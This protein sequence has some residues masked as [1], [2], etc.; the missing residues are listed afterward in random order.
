[1]ARRSPTLEAMSK[2]DRSALEKRL[3]DRQS[4]KCFICDDAIDLLLQEGQL[5]VDHI[6]PLNA[7]GPDEEN[8]FAIVHLSCNRI[9]GA[10]DLRVARRMAEFERLQETARKNGQRGANLGHLLNRYGGA[11]ARLRLKHTGDHIE[12]SL[13]EVGDTRILTAPLLKDPLSEMEFF[14]AELPLEYLHH[15]DRINPRSIGSSIRAL[16]EEFMKKRPQLHIA[17][18]WWSPDAEGSGPVKVFDG[19]HK[20]A[21][22]I[23]LGV[24]QLPVRIFLEP[25]TNVLL[26][27]NT[28]AGG[29]LRQVAFDT[30]VMRHLG[31]TLYVER[32]RQFQNMK[33][34]KEDDYSFSE[35]DLV[36]F[37]RGEHRDML[38]YIID[39]T[40]DA[41]THNKENRLMEFVEWAGKS[42][43][44]PLAYSTIERTFFREFVYKKALESAIEE[45]VGQGDNPR[46]LEQDQIVRLMNLFADIFFVGQWDPEVGGRRLENRLQKGNVIPENHLRGWR[47]A[48]EEILANVMRWVRLV[49]ENYYAWTGKP[50]QKEKLLH[51]GSP[52][53][54]WRRIDLFL[55]NLA[56]LPC[57]VD[58]N[59]SN[60]VFGAKQNL[61][62]WARVFETGIT[63][64]G[65]RVLAQ[66]LELSRMIQENLPIGEN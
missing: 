16:I 7:N 45:G 61:D 53:E 33:G 24:K 19:Q 50:V 39:A 5:E 55:R 65:V 28:N 12:Y 8:N 63:P 4:G 17:L 44:R 1:M 59:L 47:I 57:W 11:R 18:A 23:L 27:T 6:V 51:R 30:A 38:R 15:D 9:K 49:I 64:T 56:E 22:Q 35:K 20:A 26:Q 46:M 37:F 41:I 2:E 13:A 40:R 3:C 60:T 52:E 31:S 34:L 42:G 66:P 10:S 58:K 36:T 25:D 54:L 29:P 43:E 14:F 21:T 48:R 62:F 32:V